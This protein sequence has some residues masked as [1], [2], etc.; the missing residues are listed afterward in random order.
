MMQKE[1]QLPVIVRVKQIVTEK[2]D[3]LLSIHLKTVLEKTT[4]KKIR[5]Y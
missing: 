1:R 3:Q 5:N 4:Q 2:Y